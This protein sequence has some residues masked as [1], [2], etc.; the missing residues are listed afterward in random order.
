M[1]VKAMAAVWEMDL[2]PE[3]KYVLLCYADHADHDGGSIYPAVAKIAKKTGYSERTV[4]RITRHLETNGQ[5][6]QDG[7][8]P[9]GT[10]RWRMPMGGGDK[11]SPPISGGDTIVAGGVTSM[12]ERGDIAMSPEP[13]LTIIKPS[14]IKQTFK[15]NSKDKFG[16][17]LDILA[18]GQAKIAPYVNII[19][20]L[21]AGLHLNLPPYGESKDVDH[22][23]HC[24]ALAEADHPDQ[25]VELF[26]T[27][28][29]STRDA[30]ELSWYRIR[31]IGIWQDWL[32][33]YVP[34]KTQPR[35][36]KYPKGDNTE[37]FKQL[38][39]TSKE[40]A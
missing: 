36:P 35:G 3:E 1:S 7:S 38:A 27:W 37:F 40:R 5:L 25:K 29:T 18:E 6:I 16:G 15:K 10:N 26:C 11:M 9:K 24:I 12:T 17:Y 33:P 4:Q 39:A 20:R 31:P 21:S 28:A 19:E 2:A 8:G 30:K 32:L 13:S 23:A 14:I 34:P 22:V